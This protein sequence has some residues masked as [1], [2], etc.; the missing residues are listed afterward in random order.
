MNEPR[1]IDVERVIC[2]LDD[3]E[4][5]GAR[6]FA[7]GGGAWP[8]RGFVVR[9]NADMSRIEQGGPQ[10][11]ALAGGGIEHFVPSILLNL[12]Q[13]QRSANT[14]SDEPACSNPNQNKVEKTKRMKTA[15]IRLISPVV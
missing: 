11:L 6:G 14:V 7:I 1:P 13:A 5:S 12:P 4:E 8:L 9:I 10:R 15:D 2:R 3:L